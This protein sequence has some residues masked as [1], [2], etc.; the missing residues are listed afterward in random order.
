MRLTDRICT[1]LSTGDDMETNAST[2]LKE[3]KE[4]A[5]ILAHASENTLVI[6]DELGRATS[7][8]DG[9]GIAW[10]VAESL[11]HAG[12]YTLLAT[13][14]HELSELARLYP[15]I[16]NSSMAVEATTTPAVESS[17]VATIGRTVSA[18][19]SLRFRCG[20]YMFSTYIVICT[21]SFFLEVLTTSLCTLSQIRS[22]H[23]ID[24]TYK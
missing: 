7:N 15:N 8:A 6:I 12:A 21:P 18:D 9:V 22:L 24:A 17:S 14:Y 3:M 23:R 20:N 5:F 1:R 16:R 10:A 19:S 4:T 13:H 11:A 2:F